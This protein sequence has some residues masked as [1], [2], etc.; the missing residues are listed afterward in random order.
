MSGVTVT[1]QAFG[2]DPGVARGWS[3]SNGIELVIP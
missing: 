3:N 2:I 1:T